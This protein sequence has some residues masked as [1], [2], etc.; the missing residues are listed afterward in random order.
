MR[1][2]FFVLLIL[3]LPLPMRPARPLKTL[4]IEADV[5]P[6][7]EKTMISVARPKRHQ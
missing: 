4:R 6:A 5:A 7:K 2:L 3:L 1:R